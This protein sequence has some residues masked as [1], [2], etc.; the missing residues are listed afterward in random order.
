MRLSTYLVIVLRRSGDGASPISRSW[1]LKSGADWE[2]SLKIT[3]KVYNIIW[4]Q[5][6]FVAWGKRGSNRLFSGGKIGENKAK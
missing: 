4:E 2:R 5:L 1:Q 3:E 6:T